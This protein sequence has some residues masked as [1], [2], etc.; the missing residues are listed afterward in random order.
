M[1]TPVFV[2][3]A[4]LASLLILSARGA[5]GSD[6]EQAV[7]SPVVIE[8]FTSEGCSSCPPA[9]LLAAEI[10]R[11][12][13]EQ[14]LPVYALELHVD[15]WDRLGWKDPFGDKAFTDRQ[16][17][18]ARAFGS[19]RLYTPQMIVNGRTEFVGSDAKRARAAIIAELAAAPR[20]EV[21]VRVE[22]AGRTWRVTGEASGHEQGDIVLAALVLPEAHSAVSSGENAGRTLRHTNVVLSLTQ[23]QLSDSGGLQANLA[24]PEAH[25]EA[26]ERLSVICFVQRGLGRKIVGV[27]EWSPTEK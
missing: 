8:L 6:D 2:A 20:V 4:S 27:G 18:Y 1:R 11:I 26:S 5:L 10:N 23:A 19:E 7:R 17:G 15:Y 16:R 14:N 22:Q 25:A 21:A 12:A 24:V 13:S 9:E 3:T